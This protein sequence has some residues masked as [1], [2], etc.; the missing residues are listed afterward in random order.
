MPRDQQAS[1]LCTQCDRGTVSCSHNEFV[2]ATRTIHS[3]E[4]RCSDCG[5]R[6]TQAFRSDVSQ[7]EPA[8]DPKVCPFCG[9]QAGA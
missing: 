1:G 5:H 9:R 6:V 7:A 4:H 8:A 2:D 3:W